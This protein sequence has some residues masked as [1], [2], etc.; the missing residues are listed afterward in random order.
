M[1]QVTFLPILGAGLSAVILGIIWYHPRVFGTYWMAHSGI[2]PEKADIAKRRM[3]LYAFIG[4]LSAMLVAYVMN[5]FGIAWSVYNWV[6][7]LQLAFWCWIG[8]IAPTMLG[9]VLWE[10]KPFKVYLIVAGY[11]LVALVAMALI[12]LL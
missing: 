3:P 7:S 10:H 11:W 2:T 8:F 12:L 4:F 9:M 1:Y 6:G 5:Y